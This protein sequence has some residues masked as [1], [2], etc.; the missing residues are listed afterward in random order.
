MSHLHFD[1]LERVL[2]LIV[3][4]N[5]NLPLL[6][7]ALVLDPHLPRQFGRELADEPRI[8]ELAR[9]AQIF[10]AAHECVRLA[11]LSGGWD[12]VGIKVLLFAAG[13]GDETRIYSIS[14]T[15]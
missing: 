5:H 14:M 15:S 2:D 12:A 11:A 9:N 8:P 3:L 1:L 7:R 4:P 6:L 13:D 10:A